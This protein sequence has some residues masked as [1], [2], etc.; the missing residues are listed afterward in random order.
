RGTPDSGRKI[1]NFDRD[2]ETNT[3]S[4]AQKG[5]TWVCHK[6]WL[7]WCMI[8]FNWSNAVEN[9]NE[10][11]YTKKVLIQQLQISQELQKENC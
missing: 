8:E 4:T 5:L 7:T 10:D 6:L 11:A 9:N 2:S 3:Q 1:E